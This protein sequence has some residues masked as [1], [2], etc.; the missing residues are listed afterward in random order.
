M[1]HD[2]GKWVTCQRFSILRFFTPHSGNLKMPHPLLVICMVTDLWANLSTLK[3]IKN[4]GDIPLIPLDH[5]AYDYS[6]KANSIPF[7]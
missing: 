2:Q 4:K 3:T 7:C 6:V 1:R 5:V